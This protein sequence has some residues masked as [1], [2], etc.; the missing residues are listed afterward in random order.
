MYFLALRTGAAFVFFG[1]VWADT[2]WLLRL[3]QLIAQN[4]AIPKADLFSFTLPLCAQQGNPQPY[5]VYQWLSELL[6]YWGYIGL[7]PI[8][9]LA[10]GALVMT[11]AFL[12]IPLRACV[13]VKAPLGWSFFAVGAAS[14][15][16]NIRCVIRPEIFTYL[17]L[18][19]CL[20][21]LQTVRIQLRDEASPAAKQI[22]WKLIA[23]LTVL[24]IIWCNLHSGFVAGIILIALYAF[25][26]LLDDV[27][28][29]RPLSSPTKTLLI[30]LA[31]SVLATLINPYGIGLWFYLP[32]L[33]F[34]PINAEIDECKPLVGLELSRAVYFLLTLGLC[35]GAALFSLWRSQRER[36]STLKSPV[37]QSS[38]LIVL[39]A[40]FMGFWMRRLTSMAALTMVIETANYIGARRSAAIW[41]D[42]FWK[43]RISFVLFELVVLLLAIPGVT[44]I[45][46]KAV[47]INVPALTRDFV[48]P[49]A[50]MKYFMENRHE[51]RV[52]GS[53]PISDMLDLYWGPHSA[54][55]IDS[56]MDAYPEKIIQEYL[57]V[58][59]GQA[60]WK[61][62]LD[63]YQIEWVFLSPHKP[64]CRFLEK[65]PDW[66]VAFRDGTAR[67]FR[68]NSQVR[69]KTIP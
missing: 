30:G 64:V 41:P 5:V 17:S 57:T 63:E 27:L 40:A 3:G 45:A 55:F 32:H 69:N 54:L 46:G 13:R 62:V 61:R 39:I 60:G 29:S 24:M 12:I 8:G 43:R 44:E 1:Y 49:F 56:R 59:Y 37:H 26:F 66:E 18:A 6:F 11:L 21:L 4:A 22:N 19:I 14:L 67:I 38:L 48:P 16:A 20:V 25:S 51:G 53:L 52:F 47:P 23:A 42:S 50:A 58:L 65:D 68:R 2:C 34:A 7:Q 31:L 33:F 9:L 10:A 15:A 35:L 28:A 36:A